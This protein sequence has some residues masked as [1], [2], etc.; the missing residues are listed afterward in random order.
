MPIGSKSTTFSKIRTMGQKVSQ[1]FT[2]GQKIGNHASNLISSI[3]SNVPMHRALTNN[4]SNSVHS[5]YAP[6]GLK[7]IPNQKKSSLTK[8]SF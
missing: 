7:R 5:I 2:I 6:T 1:P 8:G 3:S 4:I